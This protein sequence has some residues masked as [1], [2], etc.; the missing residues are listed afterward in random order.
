MAFAGQAA[1]VE[2]HKVA[3][4]FQSGPPDLVILVV[5]GNRIGASFEQGGV[6]TSVFRAF[7]LF[8]GA[9]QYRNTM[10]RVRKTPK[11]I[12]EQLDEALSETFP[13]SDPVSVGRNDHPGKP[14]EPPPEK[15]E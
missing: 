10:A 9:C 8:G 4:S 7:L 1:L 13:A 5:I 2:K 3:G 15:S 12:D 6:G 14:D 11:D